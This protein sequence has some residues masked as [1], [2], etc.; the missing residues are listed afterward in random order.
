MFA[1]IGKVLILL[2]AMT[3]AI[4][5]SGAATADQANYAGGGKSILLNA[6][7]PMN[8]LKSM[9]LLDPERF[10][11]KNSYMMS[12][13]SVGGSG[14]LMGMYLNTMEYRFN[15]PLIMRLQVAYQSQ[16]GHLFGNKNSFTG[17]PNIEDGRMYIPSFDLIY[18]PTKNTT[19]S[20]H[21]R[22][23][24]SGYYGYGAY[25]YSNRYNRMFGRSPFGMW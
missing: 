22:D 3:G 23:F 6:Q 17:N 12:F 20:F 18:K 1:R 10:T 2:T 25:G 8:T 9:S 13:S 24:S 21:Y 5:V 15:C 16:T 19:L 14:S 4:I 7:N 11:M